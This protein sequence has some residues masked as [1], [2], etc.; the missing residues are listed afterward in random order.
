VEHKQLLGTD[1][2][3]ETMSKS[4]SLRNLD[5]NHEKQTREGKTKSWRA[6]TWAKNGA[7]LNAN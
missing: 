1:S 7:K 2:E 6:L 5:N 4:G 3:L